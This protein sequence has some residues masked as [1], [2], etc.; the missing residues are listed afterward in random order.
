M[1]RAPRLWPL[2]I[3]VAAIA[4]PWSAE[5]NEGQWPPGQLAGIHELAKLAGLELTAEQ[6]WSESGGLL[7][8]SVNIGGCTAAFISAEGLLSTNHHCAYGALQA[9]SSVDRDYL[10]DG[11]LAATR[12]DE[13]AAGQTVKILSGITDVS[14]T[15]HDKITAVEDDRARA[16]AFDQ[17]RNELIDACESAKPH[18]SCQLASFFGHSRFELHEYTELLDVRLVYAPPSAIGEYGGE[19][20]NWMWPRHTGDFSLLRAYVGKDGEPAPYS[21]D[22]VPFKPA[23]F[24]VPSPD[25]VD[26]GDFVAIL[27][28]P[29]HTDRYMWGAELERHFF[30]WLPMRVALYGEWI[31]ILEAGT[32]RDAAVGIKVAAI[33]K[34]LANRQKNAAGKL[35]GLERLGLVE[36]RLAEDQRL[37][38]QEDGAA[39]TIEELAAISAARSERGA[40]AFLLENLGY[41][42]RSLAIARDLTVWAQQRSKPDVERKAGYRDRDRDKLWKRLEQSAK[43][44][45]P[46]VDI[47]LL[48]SFLAHADALQGRRIAGFDKLLGRSKGAGLDNR[49]PYLEAAKRAL[50]G[51]ALADPAALQK[52]FDDPKA[53]GKSKDPMLVL[54]RALMTDLD[55]LAQIDDAERG[56]LLLVEPRYFELITKV[57]RQPLYPDANSTLRF[58]FATIQGYAKWDGSQQTPQT[59]LAGAVAKHQDAGE[60]DLPDAV[61]DKADGGPECRWADRELGD[62]PIAF[63]A[64]GDT[65]GGNSGSPV[66]DSKGRLIG[67]NFDRVWEN[68]AGDYAW[69]TEQSRNVISDVRYLYWMLDEVVAG[70]HLLAEL[71]VADYQPPAPVETPTVSTEGPQPVEPNERGCACAV[72]HPAAPLGG[73]AGSL[74]LIGLVLIRRRE[75]G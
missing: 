74:L 58:S 42:P 45:D 21:A 63:L 10:K 68:V 13:L 9:N 61:L 35:A 23:Q 40:W 18:R 22:N 56:R 48:A 38:T 71:G 73:V 17:V 54:A 19:T 16:K 14:A 50:S 31:A 51:S 37:V 64:D 67:F 28:Y 27:G 53:I 69:R 3:L 12:A 24:L 2:L 36:T 43:D 15:V 41:A 72:D 52:L 59:T 30:T 1:S 34:S 65:T 20:D 75:E 44:L 26:E 32:A 46:Q 49:E 66:I 60:F 39:T 25:G 5:A 57:R 33:K 55:A 47:E 8:A 11:F 6:L 4:P 29:G 62:V 70:D 7:R